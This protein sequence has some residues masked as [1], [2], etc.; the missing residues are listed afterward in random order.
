MTICACF[1]DQGIFQALSKTAWSSVLH[2]MLGYNSFT[3]GNISGRG[4][5]HNT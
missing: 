3:G 5:S 4:L 2:I 1:F